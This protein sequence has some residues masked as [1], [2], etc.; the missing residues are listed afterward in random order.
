MHMI[1]IFMK[2]SNLDSNMNTQGVVPM[3]AYENGSAAMDWLARA[4]GFVE[5][6]RVIHEGCLAHGE[7]DT[8]SGIIML[9]S[10]SPHYQGPRSHREHCDVARRWSSVPWIIDG[11]LVYVNNIKEH[12]KR[13]KQEGAVMLSEIEE[14]QLGKIYR[15]E[16][17]EGHRW[18]FME[19][20]LT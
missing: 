15:V 3:I 9:A 16:D 19:Q 20:R 17:I 6:K 5:R 4:F 13:A 10:P 8:G 18:M 7:M 11:V 1:Q 12:Y 14:G 2:T